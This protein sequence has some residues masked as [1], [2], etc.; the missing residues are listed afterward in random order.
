MTR[1]WFPLGWYSCALPNGDYAVLFPESHIETSRGAVLLPGQNVLFVVCANWNGSLVLGGQGQADGMA[2]LWNGTKW[3]TVGSVMTYGTRPCAFGPRGLYASLMTEPGNVG[4][5]H[6]ITG[7]ALEPISKPMGA[8]GIAAVWDDGTVHSQDEFT[9][10]S[11]LAEFVERDGLRIGQDTV[12]GLVAAGHGELEPGNVQFIQFNKSGNQLAI[13]EWKPDDGG[14]VCH[15]LTTEELP[16][17]PV[18]PT[19]GRFWIGPNIGSIDQIDLFEDRANLSGVETYS[20]FV[21]EILSNVST[22]QL[23]SN[24]YPNLLASGVFRKLKEW[25][26]P[27]VI[28]MGSV[29]PGDCQA[30]NAVDGLKTAVQRVRDGGGDVAAIATDEPLVSNQQSCGGDLNKAADAHA[31]FA[32]ECN[33]L[34]VAC[35]LIEAWPFSGF[36]TIRMFLMALRDR[37]AVPAF[38]HLDINWHDAGS[39]TRV[40][41]FINACKGLSTEFGM[42]IGIYVNATKDPIATDVEHYQNL[43][44]LA[45]KIQPMYPDAPQVRVVAWAHRV[46]PDPTHK[47]QNVPNNFGANGLLASLHNTRAVFGAGIPDTPEPPPVELTDM[48]AYSAPIVGFQPGQLEPHPDGNGALLVRKPNGKVVCVTPDGNLE[49]RDAAG[50]WEKFVR[51]KNGAS[52]LAEREGGRIYVLSIAE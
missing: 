5:F 14:S 4:V 51:A 10:Q 40:K 27:L 22:P 47:T 26:I 20:I 25:G 18:Y 35:G 31:A 39:D 30:K 36:N 41:D 49:E 13:A 16:M 17:P 29:K 11:G 33:A 21:Q 45:K 42:P 7:A 34:G 1:K 12:S 15:F 23:G 52:L 28:E 43:D 24:I 2:W 19:L 3:L 48:M 37:K 8:R 32:H 6:P 50:P 46:S 38:L 44:A 9:N